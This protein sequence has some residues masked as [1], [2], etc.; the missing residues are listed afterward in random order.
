[1]ISQTIADIPEFGADYIQL[2]FENAG[3][4]YFKPEDA[5]HIHEGLGQI[6]AQ[7]AVYVLT[8]QQQAEQLSGVLFPEQ[9][10]VVLGSGDSLL[11]KVPVEGHEDP[12][13]V[14]PHHPIPGLRV[15]GVQS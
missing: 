2:V 6:A 10:S 12:L 3:R 1:M 15:F 5:G 8:W 11:L 4:G 9:I 13:Y 7:Q 14:V